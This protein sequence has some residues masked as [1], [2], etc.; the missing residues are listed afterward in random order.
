[1]AK[2][3]TQEIDLWGFHSA[4]KGLREIFNMV[5]DVV[6]RGG[7]A[8]DAFRW[9]QRKKAARALDVLRFKEGGFVN[10][11]RRIASGDFGDDDVAALKAITERTRPDVEESVQQLAKLR[12]MIRVE[13]GVE[14]AM[15]LE[16]ILYGDAG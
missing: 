7:K 6:A 3:T 15:Y 1:M 9:Y 13:V 4:A 2:G 10:V 11:L 12:D 5:D 16:Q 14:S 8:V